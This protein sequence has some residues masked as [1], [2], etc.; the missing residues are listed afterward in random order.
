MLF[1]KVRT[2][3]WALLL[4]DKHCLRGVLVHLDDEGAEVVELFLVAQLGDE[5]DF[6]VAAVEV[7]VEVEQMRFEQWLGSEHSGARA[8]ARHGRARRAEAVH[9]RG[10]DAAERR[11]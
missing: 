11:L 4:M 3:K 9:P 8:Q 2:W 10:V 7:F 1:W 5:F 6:D